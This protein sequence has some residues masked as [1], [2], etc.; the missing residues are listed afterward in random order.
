MTTTAMRALTAC[1]LV[2]ACG[3][4]R[5]PAP[6]DAA[7]CAAVWQGNIDERD[8]SSAQCPM[9]LAGAGESEGHVVLTFEAP[10]AALGTVLGIQLDLGA[11]PAPGAYTSE[12]TRPWTALAIQ[13]VAD[14]GACV[15]TAG[16]N[17]TPAGSFV[18]D[19]DAIDAETAHGSLALILFVLPQTTEQGMQSDC[20]P[21]TTEHVELTF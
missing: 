6:P 2:A 11:A 8:A 16:S 7:A 19:L 10:S 5:A 20:G 9:V 3:D 18:L 13:S 12:T 15:F 4:N 1:L 17:S 14:A 21:G